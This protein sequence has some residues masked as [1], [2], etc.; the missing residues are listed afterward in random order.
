MGKLHWYKRDPNAA[1]GG[2]M[3]LSLEERGAYNTVLDLIYSHDDQLMD[4]DRFIAGW[5]QCDVRVWRRLKESLI[6]KKKLD[7]SGGLLRNFR[8]TSEISRG[9][10]M[11]D[12]RQEAGRAGGVKSGASRS[13]N[14]DMGEA[15]AK[16]PETANDEA[17]SNTSTT[18]STTTT[19]S[20]PKSPSQPSLA[21]IDH[22]DL[23]A[24]LRKV[25]GENLGTS[26]RLLDTSPIARLMQDGYSLNDLIL[27]KIRSLAAQNRKWATWDYVARIIRTDLTPSGHAASGSTAANAAPAVDWTFRMKVARER[28]QWDPKWGVIPNQTG[29]AVPPDL[30]L[31]E[32]G[33]DW[34]IWNPDDAR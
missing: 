17:K 11:I 18:T 7:T 16:A 22:D 31:P 15:T 28:R 4:D 5:L 34:T 9:L 13:K 14:N 29:C 33:K 27:P 30:L 8:A 32:D 3:G 19:R 20:S 21:E 1:L 24:A 23:L 6:S 2:M 10:R 26:P 25:C 12:Q